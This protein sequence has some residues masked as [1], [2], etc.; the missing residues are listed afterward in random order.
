MK[1]ICQNFS[2]LGAVSIKKVECFALQINIH[3]YKTKKKNKII[4]N[5]S[6]FDLN[7]RLTGFDPFAFHRNG[8]SQPRIHTEC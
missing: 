1:W 6:D 8:P 3:N 5:C 7:P 2:L 4:I